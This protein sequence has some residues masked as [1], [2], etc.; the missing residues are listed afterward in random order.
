MYKH[1]RAL[2]YIK[3]KPVELKGELDRSTISM[4]R[5]QSLFNS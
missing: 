3:Q 4:W 1:P 2:K 5:L